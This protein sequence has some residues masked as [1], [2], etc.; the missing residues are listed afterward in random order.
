MWEK[1]FYS[2]NHFFSQRSINDCHLI[3]IAIIKVWN[4]PLCFTVYNIL[5]FYS[6]CDRKV[7]FSDNMYIG[8]AFKENIMLC[9]MLRMFENVS[10]LFVYLFIYSFN[11]S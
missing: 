8:Y 11:L 9:F 10:F 6:G 2:E 4:V 1:E 5:Q 3:L 7:H